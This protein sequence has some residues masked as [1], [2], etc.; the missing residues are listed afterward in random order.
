MKKH[1]NFHKER[2]METLNLQ[3]SRQVPCLSVNSFFLDARAPK[4]TTETRYS[5]EVA[6][7]AANVPIGIER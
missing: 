4:S 1:N 7:C 3:L 2:H 5:A 6:S